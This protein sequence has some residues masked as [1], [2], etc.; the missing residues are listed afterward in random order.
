MGA[1]NACGAPWNGAPVSA[2]GRVTPGAVGVNAQVQLNS[3]GLSAGTHLGYI[4]VASND[5]FKPKVAA[6]VVLTVTP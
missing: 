1:S 4:C 3:A 5:P 2:M 6:R